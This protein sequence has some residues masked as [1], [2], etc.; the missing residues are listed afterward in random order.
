MRQKLKKDIFIGPQIRDLMKDGER[1][2]FFNGEEVSRETELCY[3]RRLL[4]DFGK[5]C[6]YRGIQATDKRDK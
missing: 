2:Y 1:F 6:P 3:A 5:G 4:L